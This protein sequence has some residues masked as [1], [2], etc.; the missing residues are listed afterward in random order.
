M[1][2]I[3]E[4]LYPPGIFGFSLAS[5]VSVLAT[6]LT[7]GLTVVSAGLTGLTSGLTVVS[8]GLTGLESNLVAAESAV[9]SKDLERKLVSSVSKL[10]Y[11]LKSPGSNINALRKV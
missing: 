10:R 2:I 7:S 8:A 11:F 9:E 5:V 4:P 6:G 1:I 3:P